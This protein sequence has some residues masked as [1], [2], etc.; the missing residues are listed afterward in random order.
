[1]QKLFITALTRRKIKAFWR[2]MS[3]LR[4]K[5]FTTI[6][7]SLSKTKTIFYIIPGIII[8]FGVFFLSPKIAYPSQIDAQKLI[9]LTNEQRINNGLPPLL[10]NDIL[11]L[12]AENK[13][14]DL[15]SSGYFGHNTPDGKNFS[16]WISDA[17]YE[18]SYVGENLA[19]D[20]ATNVGVMQGWINSGKHKENILNDN[21]KEIG[22]A[23]V[24]GEFNN[25]KTVLIVQ[26]FGAQTPK[27]EDKDTKYLAVNQ[28]FLLPRFLSSNTFDVFVPKIKSKT[29]VRHNGV[30]S[31]AVLNSGHLKKYNNYGKAYWGE[32]D[33]NEFKFQK[34]NITLLGEENKTLTFYPSK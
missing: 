19:M 32:V 14:K 31:L 12:A 21:Y 3:I 13:A 2:R 23:A 10:Y 22:I 18:Y 6:C 8:L 5:G 29:I 30:K 16:L 7:Q 15:L 9:E 28:A 17:G 1:M 24:N 34:V 33:G 27:Q 11:A 26:I 20:F 4:L 25:K